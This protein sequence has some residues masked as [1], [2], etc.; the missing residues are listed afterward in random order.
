MQLGSHRSH[1]SCPEHRTIAAFATSL[2]H[3]GGCRN[4]WPAWS[5]WHNGGTT[6]QESRLQ[7]LQTAPH[8]SAWQGRYVTKSCR[9]LALVHFIDWK[10]TAHV[11]H[12]ILAKLGAAPAHQ[13]IRS[14]PLFCLHLLLDGFAHLVLHTLVQLSSDGT[15][16]TCHA[17]LPGLWVVHIDGESDQRAWACWE[18]G[19]PCSIGER[20][21]QRQHVERWSDD[22]WAAGWSWVTEL[23]PLPLCWPDKS[24]KASR[25][26]SFLRFWYVNRALATV[27]CTFLPTSASKKCSE[28][29]GS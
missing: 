13:C 2:D 7:L 8:L 5:H 10:S 3:L 21:H 23:S 15:C 26:F 20:T 11:Q 27:W 16:K 9:T 18:D 24:P 19:H 17:A 12:A 14:L 25:P 1:P 22:G 28:R 4:A 6:L 29:D